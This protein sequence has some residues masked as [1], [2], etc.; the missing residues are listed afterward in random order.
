MTTMFPPGAQTE[1]GCLIWTDADF[2]WRVYK[3]FSTYNR[4]KD[5]SGFYS[6]TCFVRPLV[7]STE[8]G[9]KKQVAYK[10]GAR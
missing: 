5:V 1:A 9:R 10:E 6:K 4:N 2:L 8:N 7:F 3:H